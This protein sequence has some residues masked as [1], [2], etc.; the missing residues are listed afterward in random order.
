MYFLIRPSSKETVKVQRQ[1]LKRH[2]QVTGLNHAAGETEVEYGIHTN[3]NELET[4]ITCMH[5]VC[6]G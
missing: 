6:C 5:Y 4:C 1:Q 3:R 2:G